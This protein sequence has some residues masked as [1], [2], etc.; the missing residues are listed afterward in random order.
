MLTY[1]TRSNG[2]QGA[3]FDQEYI[4][5][6]SKAP[7]GTATYPVTQI[8]AAINVLRKYVPQLSAPMNMSIDLD[9]GTIQ[10]LQ[11]LAAKIPKIPSQIK[12]YLPAA[13]VVTALSS[14][15]RKAVESAVGSLRNP[16]YQVI[17]GYALYVQTKGQQGG[18]ETG[19]KVGETSGQG[20][21]QNAPTTP[22]YKK[23]W[24][25]IA[26]VGGVA[27]LG[28]GAYFLARK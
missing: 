5:E 10:A 25:W 26:T 14:D 15:A 27:A 13:A 21:I 7:A 28:T 2:L 3:N 6:L 12:T 19:L 22:I 9:F 24:F 4:D 1:T 17:K 16:L 11:Q 8:K 23:P 18:A 20:L